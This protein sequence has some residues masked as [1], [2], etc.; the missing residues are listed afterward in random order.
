MRAYRL[1]TAAVL[2]IALAGCVPRPAAPVA[3][4]PAPVPTPPPAPVPPLPPP[5]PPPAQDWR[6]IALTPGDWTYRPD[7]GG[8]IA[9]FGVGAPDFALRCLPAARQIVMDRAGAAA[10]AP[11]VVRTSFGE[12]IVAAGTPLPAGDPLLDQMAFSRGRFTVAAPG[13]PMLVIPA[14]PEPA[15]TIEDCRG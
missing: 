5:A 3:P 4:P 13:L 12:R 14:W 1:G 9:V 10:G 11:L 2:A 15:R 6:D 8:S 7:P